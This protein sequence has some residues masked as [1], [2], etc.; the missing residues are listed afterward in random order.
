MVTQLVSK[1]YLQFLDTQS[2]VSTQCGTLQSTTCVT[3]GRIMDALME[4]GV[5]VFL[6][7]VSALSLFVVA[8][9]FSQ[10]NPVVSQG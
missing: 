8:C 9:L 10:T 1:S 2:A 6:L 3:L 4:L 7:R 5:M